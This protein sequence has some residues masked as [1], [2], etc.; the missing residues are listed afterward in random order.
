MKLEFAK[1]QGAGNDFV[2]IDGRVACADVVWT[3]ERVSGLCDRRFGV[4]ADGL[5]VLENDPSGSDFMMRYF[6][7]DGGE[8]TM[9]GNGGRCIARF[10]DDLA[11]G[12]CEK[13]F[14]AVDGP[15]TAVLNA[16][17]TIT[18]GM[19][20]MA[21]VEQRG[22]DFFVQSGSPHY[23]LIGKSYDQ[24]QAKA[25]RAVHNANV[26]YVQIEA[27]GVLSIRTF[28]RGVEAETWACGTGAVASAAAVDAQSADKQDFYTLRALGGELG[29]AFERTASGGYG[30]VRL[31]GP[32][33]RVFA[34]ELEI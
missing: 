17:G 6:N 29:V 4:G 31:T 27:P 25:L 8:S 1:Y 2:L 19:I 22:A 10:A 3:R 18:L 24:V 5:M 30:N 21:G 13:R 23:I 14:V 34:G 9:C 28:E 20:D 15:H 33:V 26:N 12:G 16:D 11:I 7:A 32:A